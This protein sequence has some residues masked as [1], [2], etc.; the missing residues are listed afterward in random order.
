MGGPFVWMAFNEQ[1]LLFD[2]TGV[3]RSVTTNSVDSRPTVT[4]VNAAWIAHILGMAKQTVFAGNLLLVRW[5]S[6]NLAACTEIGKAMKARGNTTKPG[7]I[8]IVPA[9]LELSTVEARRVVERMQDLLPLCKHLTIVIEAGG[10]RGAAQRR[11]MSQVK[12]G[13]ARNYRLSVVSTISNALRWAPGPLVE[14]AE[15]RMACD[16]IGASLPAQL[17]ACV[18]PSVQVA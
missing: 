5:G 1:H 8:C 17:P 15:L 13:S 7:C 2:M 4:I 16:S 11:L 3:A 9:D 12:L 14:E 6:S 18:P 10:A